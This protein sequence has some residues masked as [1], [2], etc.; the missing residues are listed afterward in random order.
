MDLGV[1]LNSKLTWV[2]QVNSMRYKANKMLGFIRWST[3]EIHDVR[4]RKSL[5]LQLV[6]NNFAYASQVWSPQTIQLIENIEKVQRRA[7]KYILNLGFTSNVPYTTRLLQLGLL[8]LSYWHE[9]LDLVLLYKII[10]GYTYIDDSGT[11]LDQQWQ[12][13]E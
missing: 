5:Y 2:N 13:L 11:V 6:R 3:K 4:A 10:N 8:P 12:V 9:Y 1:V 7:T